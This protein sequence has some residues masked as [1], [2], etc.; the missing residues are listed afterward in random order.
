MSKKAIEISFPSE[1]LAPVATVESYRKE[2]YRPIYHTHK[3]W[4]QRLG[5][6]F[7]AIVLGATKD[8]T[9]DILKEFYQKQA[10]NDFIVLDP[11][12]GSGTTVG[13][14][15][16]A[17]CKAIGCDINP[18]S[19]F[20]VRQSLESVNLTKLLETFEELERK[21]KPKINQYFTRTHPRTGETCQV[22]YY[23]W[24]KTV[25]MPDGHEIPLFSNY[26]FSKNAY[27]GKKPEAKIVCPAC[28][29]INT[30]R[31]NA[32][33]LECQ[34]CQHHFNPQHGPANGAELTDFRT[35]QKFKILDLVRQSP[36]GK[37]AERMFAS[38][39]L[40]P[41]GEKEYLPIDEQDSLLFGNAQR[42]FTERGFDKANFPIEPGHN[43]NQA[44]NYG[45]RQWRDFFN[46]RQL[47][48]LDLLLEGILEIEEQNVREQFLTLFSG[49]LE[50]NNMFCSF[51]GEG[52]GAVRHIFSHHILKPE[53]TPLENSV[54]GCSKSSGTFSTLFQS[55]LLRAKEYLKKPFELRIEPSG[56]SS[57]VFCNAPLQPVFV[58]DFKALT[59]TPGACLLLNGNSS[60][61]PLPDKSVDAVVTDPPYFDFVHYSEL[62]DFFHAWLAPALKNQYP[63]FEKNTSRR[64]GEV[65]HK[66]P[67]AF[68]R[69]LADVFRE[70]GRVLKNDGVLVFSF[71]HS[72]NEAWAAIL[73][74]LR[75]AGFQIGQAYPI[76]AEMSVSTP[77][78]QA[79]SPINLDALLVCK[80]VEIEKLPPLNGYREETQRLYKLHLNGHTEVSDNDRKVV[81]LSQL[82]KVLSDSGE[83]WAVLENAIASAGEIDLVDFVPSAQVSKKLVLTLFD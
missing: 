40:L 66:T 21:V 71:H 39:V 72:R 36:G 56:E 75:E 12:M 67:E 42:D 1:Q 62:A 46:E 79:K 74:A 80:K 6:I 31:Y 76:K 57:K 27:P 10:P 58:Q 38:M 47:L 69:L 37:P 3:W 22:L 63:F 15:L 29:G 7:R 53:R 41:N 73:F 44:L 19:T 83:K 50:F 23:F 61:L 26:V 18:V 43:T 48:C 49:T 54:W 68:A 24:V 64:A 9:A 25:R 77:K 30:A 17:G 81:Y 2:V 52:T 16:K 45:Y 70:C 35:G 55:R 60:N 5:S 20:I 32:I 82:I 14:A 33:A 59:A 28:F 78:A 51:K 13:E 8:E 34:N 11:F 65:Q 4:A